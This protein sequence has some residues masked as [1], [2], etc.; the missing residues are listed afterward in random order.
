MSEERKT[1][2]FC[3][4]ILFDVYLTFKA[5]LQELFHM[6]QSPAQRLF[7]FGGSVDFRGLITDLSKKAGARFRF[8]DSFRHRKQG[9]R[10]HA[11]FLP[12]I[13]YLYLARYEKGFIF[14]VHCIHPN[15][16]CYTFALTLLA[17]TVRM[18]FPGRKVSKTLWITPR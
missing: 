1:G 2:F 11:T 12:F 3:G 14:L 16:L 7:I 10:I 4:V 5:G 9:G 6:V 8:H 17:N 13:S 18:N 15:F